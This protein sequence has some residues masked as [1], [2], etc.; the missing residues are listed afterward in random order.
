MPIDITKEKPESLSKLARTVYARFGIQ[1]TRRTYW[2]W[3]TKGV[4]DRSKP[5]VQVVTPSGNKLA[6]QRLRLEKV[7]I[8]GVIHS[9][10]EAYLRFVEELSGE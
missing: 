7:V 8:G 1:R 6:Y 2:L 4:P 3:T 5:Q 10:V 9:T